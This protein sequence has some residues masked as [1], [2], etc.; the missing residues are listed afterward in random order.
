MSLFSA[1]EFSNFKDPWGL[2]TRMVR[3]GDRAALASLTRAATE[4]V[5][6][7]LDG[8]LSRRERRLVEQG[9]QPSQ[10][11]VLVVGGARTGSTMV[12]Q[13]L[14]AALPVSYFTNVTGVFPRSPITATGLLVRDWDRPSA[15]LHSFY[16]QTARWTGPND[17]FA[18]WNRWFGHDRYV[19]QGV[20]VDEAGRADM[21]AFFGAW[22]RLFP[23]PFLNKNNRNTSV[24]AQLADLLP[25]AV[26]VSVSRDPLYVGQSLVMA[27]QRVQGD[28]RVPWGLNAQ[29]TV[30]PSLP[31]QDPMAY[32]DDVAA[33]V[34]RTEAQLR[35]QLA[36]LPQSRWIELAYEDV[37]RD[38]G[39]AIRRVADLV[40]GLEMRPS[41]LDG[42]RPDAPG[43]TDRLGE[44]ELQRLRDALDLRYGEA[45]G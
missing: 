40:P 37:C 39:D 7:P 14:A 35:E 25:T 45:T 27:R 16:G 18:V 44:A 9:D 23:R 17:G 41:S 20:P 21:R 8:A 26:F 4:I 10:P 12:Y 15:D 28:R 29:S 31:G 22:T 13:M 5:A 24:V 32:L 34:H 2:L 3:S 1:R 33:Q 19:A 30:D 38:P 42:P 11:L 43:N 36:G 6:T